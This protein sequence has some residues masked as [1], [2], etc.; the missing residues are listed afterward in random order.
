MPMQVKMQAIHRPIFRPKK[1]EKMPAARDDTRAPRIGKDV[2]SCWKVDCGGS[3]SNVA[4]TFAQLHKRTHIEAIS[5]RNELARV[6]KDNEETRQR[7][8][9]AHDARVHAK[10]K[11]SH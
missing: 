8:E 7:L 1:T 2:I 4:S 11:V 9:T 6:A 5:S 3:V 10:L